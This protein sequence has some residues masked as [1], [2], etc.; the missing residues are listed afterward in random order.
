VIVILFLYDD[1]FVTTNNIVS[2]ILKNRHA[3][4][5]QQNK[6]ACTF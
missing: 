2:T 4:V 6:K 3:I 1:P 5:K